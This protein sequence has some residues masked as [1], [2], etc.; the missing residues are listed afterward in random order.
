MRNFYNYGANQP[1]IDAVLRGENPGKV[2]DDLIVV[3]IGFCFGSL[4]KARAYS[5]D[6]KTSMFYVSS[7]KLDV[8]EVE[9]PRREYSEIDLIKPEVETNYTI[10]NFDPDKSNWSKV[11]FSIWGSVENYKRYGIGVGVFDNDKQI[12]E[13]MVGYRGKSNWEIGVVTH[14]D[15]RMQGLSKLATYYLVKSLI[16][17]G[18]HPSWSCHEVNV[19]SYKVAESVGFK[20]FTRYYLYHLNS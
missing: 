20:N 5:V 8:K 14:E 9:I 6:N 1:M 10:K 7:E 12:S 2:L 15:Y 18:V 11:M 13:A 16:D 17:K 4:E 19:G 3:D